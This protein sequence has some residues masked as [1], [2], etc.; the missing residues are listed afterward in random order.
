VEP[1]PPINITGSWYGV[2]VQGGLT[3][4]MLL[5]QKGSG[6]FGTFVPSLG[7]KRTVP[8]SDYTSCALS[9]IATKRLKRHASRRPVRR[10]SVASAKSYAMGCAVFELTRCGGTRNY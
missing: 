1:P 8:R 2:K 7:V 3:G 4:T 5:Q 9:C 6:V 10:S